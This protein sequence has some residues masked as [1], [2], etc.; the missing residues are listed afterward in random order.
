MATILTKLLFII[1]EIVLSRKICDYNHSVISN[2]YRELEEARK[3]RKAYSKVIVRN[4]SDKEARDKFSVYSARE[5]DIFLS[6]VIADP[7][8]R[9]SERIAYLL[10]LSDKHLH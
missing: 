4:A 10:S 9:D 5:R 3:M 2:L 6:L 7:A 1:R 8:C